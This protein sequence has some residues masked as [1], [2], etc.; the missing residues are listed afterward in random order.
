MRPQQLGATQSGS[1][2]IVEG[3]AFRV[4][5]EHAERD[6]DPIANLDAE[7]SLSELNR[8]RPYKPIEI[9]G[10]GQNL[11]IGDEDP[12][13]KIV[14]VPAGVSEAMTGYAIVCKEDTRYA[15]SEPSRSQWISLDATCPRVAANAIYTF[16]TSIDLTGFDHETV[17]IQCQI[18]ADNGVKA[19]RVNGHALKFD[20]WNDN[21]RLQRFDRTAFRAV[22]ID[23]GLVPGNNVVEIDVWNGGECSPTQTLPIPNPTALRV[24]WH[25]FG[26]TI[27]EIEGKLAQNDGP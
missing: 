20:A 5:G 23:Q 15:L 8:L 24:E 12:N 6:R 9:P 11:R 22:S 2:V 7:L 10:S 13:W 27:S 21:V 17:R 26:N 19:I 25:A 1:V 18:L 3:E 4:R 16:Q 14:S